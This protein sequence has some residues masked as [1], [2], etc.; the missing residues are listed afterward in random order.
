MTDMLILGYGPA[1][2]SAALY[3]LRAGLS[4]QLIGKDGGGLAKAHMIQN[5]YGLEKP[6]SGEELLE[7]GHKQ[8]MAL[9]AKIIDDEI[10][11]LMFDGQGF[12]AKGLVGEYHGKVCIMAT[13]AARNKHPVPGMAELEGHGVSYCAVCDAF[14]Y[15]QKKVAVLGTGEYALHEVQELAQVVASITLLTNGAPLT[16]SFPPN[17]GRRPVQGRPLRR[18]H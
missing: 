5:Y 3:G 10:T 13:G 16:A 7:V 4:V 18:R 2:I 8:A 15:R 11:D 14:F 6:L 17:G 9:G 12:S 1:G